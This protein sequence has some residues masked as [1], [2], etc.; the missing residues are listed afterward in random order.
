M[1][2]PI[3]AILMTAGALAVSGGLMLIIYGINDI[4]E[5]TR[6]TFLGS[7]DYTG[8][9]WIVVGFVLIV[10]G[11]VFFQAAVKP[12]IAAPQIG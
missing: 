4:A 1:S 8:L 6:R 7:T 3:T 11:T 2:L 9:I 5:S 10:F 12:L